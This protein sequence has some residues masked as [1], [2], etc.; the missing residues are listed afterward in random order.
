MKSNIR[1]ETNFSTESVNFLDVTVSIQREQI[2]TSLY[3]KPT[4]AHLYLNAKSCHPKHVVKN[5]PKGQFIRVRRICSEDADFEQHAR[6]MMKFF[7]QRGYQEKDLVNDI[8]LV[9]KM[10]R[11]E[12]LQE[13]IK[14]AEKDPQ[15]TFVCTW[16]PKL[17]RL[18][19]ILNLIC[20]VLS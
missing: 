18:S 8:S 9:R 12:L 11:N 2:R 10:S 15:S 5:L 3:T 1:F 16:H 13:K 6:E 4:D 14:T 7:I 17:H 19:A 20:Q